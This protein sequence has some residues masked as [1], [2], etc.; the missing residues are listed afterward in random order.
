MRKLVIWLVNLAVAITLGALVV[1]FFQDAN[2]YKPQLLDLMEEQLGVRVDVRGDLSWGLFPPLQLTA[3]DVHAEV[4]GRTWSLGRLALHVSVWSLITESNGFED[5][6]IQDLTLDDLVMLDGDA[7]LEVDDLDLDNLGPDTA[8]PLTANMTYSPAEGKPIPVSL[9]GNI[10]YHSA[11]QAIDVNDLAFDTPFGNGQC[12]LNVVPSQRT[13]PAAPASADAL[14]PIDALRQAN[15][16]GTCDLADVTFEEQTFENVR[17]VLDNQD[18]RLHLL[19]HI[20]AFFGGTADLEVDIAA[21]QDP[22]TWTITPILENV[23]SQRLVDWLDQSLEWAAPI[24]YGGTFEL[25]GNTT[26]ALASSVT[27]ETHF[28]GGQGQLDIS[29]IRQQLLTIAA[30]IGKPDTILR[31]P[32]ILDYQRFV[33]DW[34]IEQQH[35]TLDFALDNLTVSAE[36]DYIVKDDRLDMLAELT[37][38]EDPEFSS[39]DVNPLLVGLPIPVRCRGSLENPTCRVDDNAA[40]RIVASA[41]QAKE[42]TELRTKL[43]EAIDEKV[44]EEYRDAARSL[45]DLLGRSLSKED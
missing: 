16:S 21:D 10:T 17:L 12:D 42:G 31:W 25:T 20:P 2:R 27:G 37:F 32:A 11:T 38:E 23:D 35:H 40:K 15:W 14:L 24:A 41:F 18:A 3:E 1:W 13:W 44:P 26:Q 4:E 30:L 8:V 29:K 22:V 43:D 33:G 34:R 36:G 6:R 19:G 45:L 28:D 39:L 7:R 9:T 5:W